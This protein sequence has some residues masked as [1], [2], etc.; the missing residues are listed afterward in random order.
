MGAWGSSVGGSRFLG[1]LSR[2]RVGQTRAG[3]EMGSVVA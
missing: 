3:R 1:E 2:R